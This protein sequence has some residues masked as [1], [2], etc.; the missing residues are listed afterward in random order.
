MVKGLTGSPLFEP[1]QRIPASV[2][3]SERAALAKAGEAAIKEAVFAALATMVAGMFGFNEAQLL[4]IE[5]AARE[6]PKVS[7]GK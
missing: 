2:P 7:F 6:A 1:F 3:E 4:E 5:S